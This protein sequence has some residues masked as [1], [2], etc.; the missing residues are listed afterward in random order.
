MRYAPRP[1]SHVAGTG[2]ELVVANLDYVLSFEHVPQFVFVL[3][4]VEG[5]VER[6]DFF[7]DAKGT[8]SSRARGSN[9]ELGI[10]EPQ[11]FAAVCSDLVAA[12]LSHGSNCSLEAEAY[13]PKIRLR[14][15]C[16]KWQRPLRG[17][18]GTRQALRR[19]LVGGTLSNLLKGEISPP[20]TGRTLT[21]RRSRRTSPRG[22]LDRGE[23]SIVP[24]AARLHQ[25]MLLGAEADPPMHLGGL[26]V[27]LRG[28]IRE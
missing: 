28:V 16:Q 19:T 20:P 15:A 8:A 22:K 24:T 18:W 4:N 23:I 21:P 27:C 17:R 3:V 9:D 2:M 7:Y 1:E 26:A 12:G 5:S 6:G 14:A 13:L 10:A 11:T 25:K